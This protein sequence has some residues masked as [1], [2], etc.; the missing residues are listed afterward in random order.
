LAGG[1]GL[2]CPSNNLFGRIT[3]E[4]IRKEGIKATGRLLIPLIKSSI[5]GSGLT[6]GKTL[7]NNLIEN[8]IK[9]IWSR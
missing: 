2:M 1:S 9:L 8:L 4:I 6:I 7:I 3:V 5:V